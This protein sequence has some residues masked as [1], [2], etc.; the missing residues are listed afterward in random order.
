MRLLEFVLRNSYVTYEKEHYHQTFGCA[1]GSPVSATIANLVMEFV[2]ERAISTAAHPPRWWYR[3]VDDSHVCL[4][5]E[6]VQE[7]HAQ[8]NSIN[9]HIQFT[10]EAES[11]NGLSFLDT[12]TVRANGRIPVHVYRKPTHT[13]NYLDFYSHHP[14]Q[15]K[16]SVFNTLLD[17]AVKIPST[18]RGK[19]KE[20]QHIM[21]VLMNNNYPLQFIKKCDSARKA[22]HR[23]SNTNNT[24]NEVTTPFVLLPYVKGVTERVSRVLRNNGIKLG[25]K[26]LSTLG[27]IFSRPKDKSTLFQSRYIVYKVNCLDCDFAYYGQTNRALATRLSEHRRAVRVCDGNSKIAQYANQFGHN[28]DVDHATS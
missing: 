16:R 4:P 10:S 7:F 1:M 20:K 18:N 19:R 8:L 9:P 25:F 26:P 24:T 15:H 17:R 22:R 5:K 2:E 23:D 14:A 11:D 13:D 6:Y 21:K 27:T 12:T 3:Y 28:I